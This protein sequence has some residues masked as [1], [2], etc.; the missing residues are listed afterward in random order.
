MSDPYKNTSLTKTVM[1]TSV[2][3]VP[4]VQPTNAQIAQANMDS[5]LKWNGVDNFNP[6]RVTSALYDEI[7]PV[8]K[9][10]ATVDPTVA[11]GAA[12]PEEKG[13]F[14]GI[15]DAISGFI[16]GTNKNADGSTNTTG[17]GGMKGV[18]DLGGGLASLY[19]I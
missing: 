1:G 17:L 12:V 7:T 14:S 11:A 9:Q 16:G 5:Y 2:N 15:T 13:F 3:G 19:S 10:P 18:A 8:V 4:S 6:D